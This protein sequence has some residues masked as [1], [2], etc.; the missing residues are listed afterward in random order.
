MH[1]AAKASF[2]KAIYDNPGYLK[3]PLPY[4]ETAVL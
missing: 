1:G 3:L 2:K 4:E